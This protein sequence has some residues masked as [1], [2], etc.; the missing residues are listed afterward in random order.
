MKRKFKLFATLASLCLSVALMAFGVYA[1]SQSTFAVTSRVSFDAQVA[2]QWSGSAVGGVNG[3]GEVDRY[4]GELDD[5]WDEAEG[6]VNY[7]D[8][9]Q[10][11]AKE[12]EIGNLKF[13]VGNNVITYTIKCKNLSATQPI[14][15]TCTAL[16]DG[17]SA[18]STI[19]GVYA[20]SGV[21]KVNGATAATASSLAANDYFEVAASGEMTVVL[22]L[23]L[24]DF[25]V[26]VDSKA[27]EMSFKAEPAA[28]A[29]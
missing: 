29:L 20:V 8:S 26:S 15:V 21:T 13:E 19:S 18:V 24:N 28:A 25:G 22:T 5:D 6:I 11:A 4:Y 17:A 7:A 9:T 10:T 14:K 23:T 16:T 3:T 27:V 2:V 12:W 1:A